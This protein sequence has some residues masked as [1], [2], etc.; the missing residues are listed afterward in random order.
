MT[1]YCVICGAPFSVPPS[2][3]KVTC[4]PECRSKRAAISSSNTNRKWSAEAKAR[5]AADV[6]IIA[7]LSSIQDIATA[8]ALERP[9]GMRGPEHRASKIWTLIDPSGNKIIVT[10]LLD[11]A[12]KN[13]DLFEPQ[14]DDVDA[15]AARISKGFQAIASSM[16]GVKSR[17]RPA[18]HYKGWS[19]DGLPYNKTK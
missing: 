9:D 8:A 13:Y 5:R 7:Q 18:R 11:W 16:R 10:N 3:K 19:L 14:C 6:R 2:S 15:A 17:E 12:R 4:S 1:K